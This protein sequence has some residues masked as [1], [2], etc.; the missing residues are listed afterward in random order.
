MLLIIPSAVGQ[1]FTISYGE[2]IQGMLTADIHQQSYYF[3]AAAGDALVIFLNALDPLGD[4]L[5]PAVRVVSDD[6]NVVASSID[7]IPLFGQTTHQAALF[8]MVPE[9]GTYTL[10]ATRR[11][12]RSSGAFRLLL[13]QPQRLETDTRITGTISNLD[14]FHFYLVRDD[15]PFLIEYERSS[16]VYAPEV[17]VNTVSPLGELI[18]VGYLAGD[19]LQQGALGVS[20]DET[21]Y[22]ISVGWLTSSFLTNVF[23]PGE[24]TAGYQLRL[25]ILD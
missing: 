24:V 14:G 2:H 25:R 1:D 20:G 17:R 10:I 13:D 15:G 19:D 21:P 18:G 4:L 12:D 8:L 16:G 9:D 5:F 11:D 7:H 3:E 23:H 22:I 6:G